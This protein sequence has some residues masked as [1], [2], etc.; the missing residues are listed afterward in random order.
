M[1]IWKFALSW[2]LIYAF[3]QGFLVY[4]ALRLLLQLVPGAWAGARYRLSL[5]AM[6]LLLLWFGG[7]WW[8]QLHTPVSAALAFGHAAPDTVVL[9]PRAG[10]ISRFQVYISG[11]QVLFPWLSG[12]YLAGLTLML[13]RLV[14]SLLQLSRLKKEGVSQPDAILQQLFER[15]RQQ[16]SAG[17]PARLLMSARA[18]APMVIGLIKPII[19][20]PAAIMTQLTAEQ[21]ETI[22]L[23]ELVH[24][25][26]HD[27][28]VNM[29]QSLVETVLFFNPFVWLISA[30]C[31]REREHSCDDAVVQHAAAPL[32]Y[33]TALAAV[34][35]AP[36]HRL[37]VAAAG[38]PHHLLHR[39]R[40][41]VEG[42]KN[43]FSYSRAA[44]AVLLVIAIASSMAW[45]P[46]SLHTRAN[47]ESRHTA[48]TP[49][50]QTQE[51]T[52]AER[53]MTDHLVDQV[54]GFVVERSGDDLYINGQ[55]QPAD[56]AGKYLS[57]LTKNYMRIEVYPLIERMKRHPDANFIQVLLPVSESSPCVDY[58][59]KKAGC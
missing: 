25:R 37:A 35:G 46:P 19:L 18:Q 53:L 14:A 20:L 44:A 6:L 58:Q 8:Q 32:T 57:G 36:Q 38:Q 34:A 56:V 9:H 10:I 49:A 13:I 47:D 17:A 42:N 41:I 27:Y 50:A 3:G 33:A 28:L 45:I 52:L 39:I 7:T 26:R 51:N 29:L 22:L 40:R 12:C 16:V 55:R 31:R 48:I 21:V 30:I 59:P 2:T 15:L 43:P 24:I 11:L 4:G 5:T 1:D 54:K 23:H